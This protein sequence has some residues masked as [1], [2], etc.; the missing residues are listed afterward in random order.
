[1]RGIVE[2]SIENDASQKISAQ[3]PNL[4]TLHKSLK[5]LRSDSAKIRGKYISIY[6]QLNFN[7]FTGVKLIV[8]TDELAHA[9][10]TSL[11]PKQIKFTGHITT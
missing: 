1:M 11:F 8:S 6:S 5:S 7:G 4:D 10:F 2:W 3:S 9:H